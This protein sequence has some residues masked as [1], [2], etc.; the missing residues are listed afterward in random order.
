MTSSWSTS[1]STIE[2]DTWTLKGQG[3]TDTTTDSFKLLL[4]DAESIKL[5]VVQ[6]WR[7][8]N[9]NGVMVSSETFLSS[10]LYEDYFDVKI[11]KFLSTYMNQPCFESWSIHGM[12]YLNDGETSA[13]VI[14]KKMP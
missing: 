5:G 11:T 2:P 8:I 12:Y 14:L 10:R 7:C 1:S 13:G 3:S 4:L 9:G 6:E